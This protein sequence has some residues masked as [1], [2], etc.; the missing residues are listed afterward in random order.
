MGSIMLLCFVSAIAGSLLTR[1]FITIDTKKTIKTLQDVLQ[2]ERNTHK[3]ALE[4]QAQRWLRTLPSAYKVGVADG[5][6]ASTKQ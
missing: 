6:K 4:D 3:I 1:L 5:S 2:L